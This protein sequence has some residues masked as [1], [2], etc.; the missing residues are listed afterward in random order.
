MATIGTLINVRLILEWFTTNYEWAFSGIGVT[1]IVA[2]ASILLRKKSG[3]SISN[4]KNSVQV[5]GNL[6]ITKKHNEPKRK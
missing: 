3:Q 2:I 4:S 6:N 1:V 5:G